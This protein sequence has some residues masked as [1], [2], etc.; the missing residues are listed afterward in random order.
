MS[1]KESFPPCFTYKTLSAVTDPLLFHMNFRIRL[2]S[3]LKIS[4]EILI[5]GDI[6]VEFIENTLI[7][8]ELTSY[9]T[10]F[11]HLSLPFLKKYAGRGAPEW[12]SWLCVRLWLRS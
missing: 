4:V 1:G 11:S 10:D 12:L 3:L 7:W 8:R 9:G 6:E 5:R 2:L